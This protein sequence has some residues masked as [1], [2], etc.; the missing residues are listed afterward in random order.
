MDRRA[1]LRISQPFP[2]T[3]SGVDRTGEP[4]EHVCVLE[5]MSS[6]GLYL[7]IPRQVERGREVR[8]IIN[9]SSTP[10][11]GAGAAIRGVTL[12]SDPVADKNW[13]LAVPISGYSFI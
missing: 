8:M 1:K 2:T 4:F 11:S 3:V 7:R 10:S 6:T 9:F 12:R 13:G 5:N